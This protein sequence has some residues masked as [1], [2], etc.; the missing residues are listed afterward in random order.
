MNFDFAALV[1]DENDSTVAEGKASLFTD[2]KQP[3]IQY[4]GLTKSHNR[5]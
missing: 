3:C 1:V 2:R 4:V 5:G